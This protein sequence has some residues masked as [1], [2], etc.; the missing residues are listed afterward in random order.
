MDRDNGRDKDKDR[1]KVRWLLNPDAALESMFE[2]TIY[3]IFWRWS[4]LFYVLS[5]DIQRSRSII[6]N[7]AA[8]MFGNKKLARKAVLKVFSDISAEPA[9]NIERFI[10]TSFYQDCRDKNPSFQHTGRLLDKLWQWRM[11]APE[12]YHRWRHTIKLTLEELSLTG[13]P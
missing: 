6:E 3:E 1:K 12:D 4:M 2:D 11:I 10:K 9:A 13:S 5:G 8:S 7:T